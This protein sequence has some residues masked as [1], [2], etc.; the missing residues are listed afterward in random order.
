MYYVSNLEYIYA[1]CHLS[2]QLGEGA[3]VHLGSALH[4]RPHFKLSPDRYG[5]DFTMDL[6]LLFCNAAR[7][8][9]I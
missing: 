3:G 9:T 2:V 1:T 8:S 7:R 4:T 6:Q 5:S